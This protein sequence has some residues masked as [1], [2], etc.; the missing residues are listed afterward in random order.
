M[1]AFGQP[2]VGVYPRMTVR[3]GTQQ[4]GTVTVDATSYAPYE[5]TVPATAGSRAISVSFDNDYYQNGQDRNLHVDSV[6]VTQ[7]VLP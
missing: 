5:F 6:Q 1:N 7:C 3:A 4:L 2:A